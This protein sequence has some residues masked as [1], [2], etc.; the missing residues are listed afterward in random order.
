MYLSNFII[1]FT[2]DSNTEPDDPSN[3]K[4]D[5]DKGPSA[6]DQST[7]T[8]EVVDLSKKPSEVEV[9]NE[10]AVTNPS[11]DETDVWS[12]NWPSFLY[13][14]IFLLIVFFL[15][16]FVINLSLVYDWTIHCSK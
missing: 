2:E 5:T 10:E 15:L 4:M 16:C 11:L 12:K 6:C 7:Q 3:D 9:T 1:F 14:H 8:E 13:C